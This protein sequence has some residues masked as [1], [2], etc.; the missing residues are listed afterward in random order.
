MRMSTPS[1]LRLAVPL[2][3]AGFLGC[4]VETQA[5]PGETVPG[6]DSPTQ[7][8]QTE[9]PLPDEEPDTVDGG[10]AAAPVLGVPCDV[11]RVVR[12]GCATSGCHT[13]GG[14]RSITTYDDLMKPS[15]GVPSESMAKQSLARLK[16]KTMP[17]TRDATAGEVGAFEA[18]AM[19]GLCQDR[20]R[21]DAASTDRRRRSRW[22]Y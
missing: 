3:F 2:A 18:W 16:A 8:P 15:K 19:Q 20:L 14:E 12:Q 5:T 6:V 7:M 1:A 10:D 21:G 9:E 13:P 11:Q 4:Y 22:R 17:P